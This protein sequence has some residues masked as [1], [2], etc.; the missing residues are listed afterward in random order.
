ME[1][2]VRVALVQL[3][4]SDAEAPAARVDRVAR[5]VRD[6]KGVADLVILPELWHVGAF[7]LGLARSHAE[8]LDGPLVAQMRSAAADSGV[9]LHAGS[10]AELDPVSGNRYNTSLLLAPHGGVAATYRKQHLFG[11]EGGESSVMSAGTGLSVAQTPLGPTGLVTCY[12]LR[13]PELFRALVTKGAATFLLTSG[14]PAERIE[15]WSVLARARAIENQAW[16]VAC[17]TAGTHNGVVMGG[18]SLVVD[19]MGAVIA[20]AGEDEQVL[21]ADID[22]DVATTWRESFPVLAD[23]RL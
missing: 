17:N 6:Q 18:R 10:F 22:P 7:A 3:D 5:L 12:D 19:P 8:P 4:V 21:Y 23:R 14:W 2:G 16:V 1:Q 20:E 9:W 13:F 11:W 15:H